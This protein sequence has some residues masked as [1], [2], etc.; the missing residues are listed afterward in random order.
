METENKAKQKLGEE[1][2]MA[3]GVS[4]EKKNKANEK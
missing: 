1:E 2:E 4:W 3:R